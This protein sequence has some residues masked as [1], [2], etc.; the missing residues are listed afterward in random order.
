MPETEQ[1]NI[2]SAALPDFHTSSGDNVLFCPL[3][4]VRVRSRGFSQMGGCY[5]LK[6]N[7]GDS[8]IKISVLYRR[9]SLIRVSVIRG[10]HFTIIQ[11]A[12]YC[13][14]VGVDADKPHISRISVQQSSVQSCT[15]STESTDRVFCSSVEYCV[16]KQQADDMTRLILRCCVKYCTEFAKTF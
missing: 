14:A 11:A 16:G 3:P 4:S 15:D 2:N 5:L 10:S 6:Y 7:G 12:M 1:R 8:G 13:K 9:C